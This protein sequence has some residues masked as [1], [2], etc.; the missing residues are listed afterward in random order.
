MWPVRPRAL[1]GTVLRRR[2]PGRERNG[3]PGPAGTVAV[4]ATLG[5]PAVAPTL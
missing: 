3:P 1:Q 4:S 2:Q 5:L